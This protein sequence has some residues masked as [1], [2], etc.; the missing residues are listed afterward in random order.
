MLIVLM[1]RRLKTQLLQLTTGTNSKTPPNPRIRDVEISNSMS[2]PSIKAKSKKMVGRLR[3]LK[4][5]KKK[6]RR[7]V[8]R[9]RLIM[10]K[11]V[12]NGLP[13]TTYIHF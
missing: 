11:L 7:A 1:R 4:R 3:K 2:L 9:M 8:M 10:K 5:R 6:R 12:A 13:K